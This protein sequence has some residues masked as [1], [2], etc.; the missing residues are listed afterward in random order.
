[1]I[2]RTH[3][4]HE[5]RFG[6]DPGSELQVAGMGRRAGTRGSYL[7]DPPH[8]RAE[9]TVPAHFEYHAGVTMDARVMSP[10]MLECHLEQRRNNPVSENALGLHNCDA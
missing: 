9:M 10:S 2:E 8:V 6:K 3:T 4:D 1:M 5:C 7:H